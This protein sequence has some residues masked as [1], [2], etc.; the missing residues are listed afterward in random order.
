MGLKLWVTLFLAFVLQ[1]GVFA[2]QEDCRK[3]DA[4]LSSLHELYCASM[5]P[6]WHCPLGNYTAAEDWPTQTVYM[7]NILAAV[8]DPATCLDTPVATGIIEWLNTFSTDPQVSMWWWN[9]YVFQPQY[10]DMPRKQGARIE[11]PATLGRKCWAFAFLKQI[12][13]A[14]QPQIIETMERAK[15]NLSKYVA[16]YDD[17][18]SMSIELC[19]EV[20]ANCFANASYDP[21]LRNG[22]CPG[23][24]S[25]FYVGFSWENGNNI[26]VNSGLCPVGD[27]WRNNSV[28]FPL[29]RYDQTDEWRAEI[30]FSLNT[31]LNYII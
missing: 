24:I 25:E 2:R 6:A 9:W 16:A 28:A 20:M 18:V 1:R 26:A 17:A 23:A 21:V 14:L 12:W 15:I 13:V 27:C 7:K 30:V 8:V 31:V 10:F 29:P 4:N 19:N 3:S 22:T 5:G 11:S